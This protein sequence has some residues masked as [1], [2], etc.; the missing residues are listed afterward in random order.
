[1]N[2]AAPQSTTLV[3]ADSHVFEP[4]GLWL[5]RTPRKFHDR[6]P[7]VVERDGGD[8]WVYDNGVTMNLAAF[9][10]A[11]VWK[12]MTDSQMKM[13][14]IRP[15][16]FDPN[17][18]LEETMSDGVAIEI[19]YP[20]YG[21]PLFGLEDAELQVTLMRAYNDWVIEYSSVA[22][23]RL[24]PV[25]LIPTLDV[26]A[27][28]VEV[29]RS[30]NLGFRGVLINAH[31]KPERD[32]SKPLYEELWA[33]L[34]ETGLPASV[35][36]YAGDGPEVS[37]ASRGGLMCTYSV[38]PARIQ[39]S[40]AQ[41]VFSGV[42]E[43]HPG[44][45]IVVVESDVGWVAALLQRMDHVFERKGSRHGVSFKSGLLPSE[46]FKRHVSCCFIEDRAGILTLEIT[47]TG[48]FM[49]G[50]D[51]PH[52]DSTWPNS[53]ESVDKVFSGLPDADRR[54]ILRDNAARLYDL[55]R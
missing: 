1:M 14:E 2:E 52:N 28:I 31:P 25:A 16:L 5:E 27:G 43:R 37:V 13:S 6:V 54:K 44:L 36:L 17:A 34:A 7:R 22:P 30:A 8:I 20:S 23:D 10:T 4:A 33:A 42:F 19:L 24:L 53:I 15:A 35:H 9:A 12:G 50:S 45:R 46:Q 41:M 38:D 29:Q 26:E 32:Y 11:G 55:P 21:M 40:L 51:Y 18:R 49:W 47:G 3:S 48:I 39:L